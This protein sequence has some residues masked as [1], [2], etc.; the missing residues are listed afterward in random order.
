MVAGWFG[1]VGCA[2][3]VWVA[4]MCLFAGLVVLCGMCLDAPVLVWF[5]VCVLV[6]CG[7]LYLVINSVD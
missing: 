7:L 3:T 1:S 6:V 4:F 2:R 5:V